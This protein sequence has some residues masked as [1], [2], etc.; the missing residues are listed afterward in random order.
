MKKMLVLAVAAFLL[1]AVVPANAAAR[2]TLP[3]RVST[4]E[5][6]V[7][8]L[9]TKV[10]RLHTFAHNCLAWNWVPIGWAG[11]PNGTVGYMYDPDGAGA[12]PPFFTSALDV[13]PSPDTTFFYAPAIRPGCISQVRA[14]ASA[15]RTELD[16][17]SL[18]DERHWRVRPR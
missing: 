4:L 17:L 2:H 7:R 12:Q 8:T 13:A 16:D 14:R 9:Q 11:D 3:H 10:N 6:K 1:A 15:M 18:A 5:G